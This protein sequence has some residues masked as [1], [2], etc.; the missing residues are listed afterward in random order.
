MSERISVSLVEEAVFN[1]P[2]GMREWRAYRIEYGGHGRECIIEGRIWL[3]PDVDPEAIENLLYDNRATTDRR[4]DINDNLA[5]CPECGSGRVKWRWDL[6]VP[7]VEDTVQCMACGHYV[8][9]KTP[10]E[11]V[12]EWNGRATAK[13]LGRLTELA[14]EHGEYE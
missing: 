4:D 9:D 6:R 13:V 7:G 8:S 12:S 11:A 10:E 1:P 2:E 5:A 14:Q 3:P